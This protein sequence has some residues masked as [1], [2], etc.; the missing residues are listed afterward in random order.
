MS[1]AA[2]ELA[3][4]RTPLGSRSS[5]SQRGV[6]KADYSFASE[7]LLWVKAVVR[8]HAAFSGDQLK[9]CGPQL[10]YDEPGYG[11]AMGQHGMQVCIPENPFPTL[12][13]SSVLNDT[14]D[15]HVLN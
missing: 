6:R 1:S 4:R 14:C 15:V 5:C 3:M 10:R 7:L 9:L 2:V 8:P 12:S 11:R 13:S